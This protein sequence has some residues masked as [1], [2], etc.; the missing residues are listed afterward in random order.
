MGRRSLLH[1]RIDPQSGTI[2]GA[3]TSRLLFVPFSSFERV[4]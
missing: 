3:V 1:V 4:I 2:E